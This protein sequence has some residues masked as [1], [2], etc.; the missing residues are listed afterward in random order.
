MHSSSLSEKGLACKVRLNTSLYEWR[1]RV[2]LI[3][4]EVNNGEVDKSDSLVGGFDQRRQQEASRTEEVMLSNPV[5]RYER[6]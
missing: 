4:H 6:R 2:D 3:N 5:P 1:A